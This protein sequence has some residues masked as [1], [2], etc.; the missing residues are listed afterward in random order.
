MNFTVEIK[1]DMIAMDT[2][3]RKGLAH[4]FSGSVTEEVVN[5]MDCPIWTYSIEE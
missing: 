5:H 4:L 2:H 1:A 3:S